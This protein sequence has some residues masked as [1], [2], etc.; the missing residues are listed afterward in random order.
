MTR[1]LTYDPADEADDPVSKYSLALRQPLC[2]GFLPVRSCAHMYVD[3]IS[4]RVLHKARRCT[5]LHM[6]PDPGA[7][8]ASL[9]TSSN[10][11]LLS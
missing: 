2:I 9:L 7:T 3:S 6:S 8:A 4:A 11:V 1:G 10:I 5:F